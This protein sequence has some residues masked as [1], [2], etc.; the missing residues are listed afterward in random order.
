MK[1][2]KY[3]IPIEAWKNLKIKQRDMGRTLKELTGKER[4][5]PLTKI[6]LAVSRKSA[7]FSNEE[8]IKLIRRKQ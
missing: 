1:Y 2:K 7:Y 5:I 4:V 3:P 8:L 6:I